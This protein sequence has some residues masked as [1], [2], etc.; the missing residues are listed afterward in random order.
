MTDEIIK[1][2]TIIRKGKDLKPILSAGMGFSFDIKP[3]NGIEVMGI[4]F[5]SSDEEVMYVVS[6]DTF[7]DMIKIFNEE[8]EKNKNE[9]M[10]IN[11]DD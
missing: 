5:P 4:I 10:K 7:R 1:R 6:K 2:K 8:S 3:I 9:K 11:W